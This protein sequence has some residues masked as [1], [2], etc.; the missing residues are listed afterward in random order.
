MAAEIAAS[1]GGTA[2]EDTALKSRSRMRSSA[3]MAR[4]RC[5]RSSRN[6]DGGDSVLAEMVRIHEQP[7]NISCNRRQSMSRARVHDADEIGARGIVYDV[8]DAV[9]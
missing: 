9:S 8:V 6:K 1:D 5:R 2:W 4:R 7:V 3:H